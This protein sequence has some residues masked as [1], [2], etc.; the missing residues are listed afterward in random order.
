MDLIADLGQYS[1]GHR[2][3]VAAVVAAVIL[4][5]GVGWMIGIASQYNP[6]LTLIFMVAPFVLFAVF[7]RGLLLSMAA[8]G[9]T[10]G[11]FALVLRKRAS[12]TPGG[13]D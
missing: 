6:L 1:L 13:G 5:W 12:S 9:V 7:G 10:H 4:L 2:G 11:L 8:A 3:D